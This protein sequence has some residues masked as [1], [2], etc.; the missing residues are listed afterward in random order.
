MKDI[1]HEAFESRR[2]S[3]IVW[4]TKTD[5]SSFFNYKLK[6]ESE[7]SSWE[8]KGNTTLLVVIFLVGLVEAVSCLEFHDALTRKRKFDRS[9]YGKEFGLP[10]N[11]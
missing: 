7:T 8:A 9:D 11:T 1:K 4:D 5:K 2:V 6:D 3:V 10:V